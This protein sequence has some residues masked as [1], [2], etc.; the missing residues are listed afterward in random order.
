MD[1]RGADSHGAEQDGKGSS[2]DLHD[3]EQVMECGLECQQ[4]QEG[5]DYS[6]LPASF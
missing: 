2:G 1:S 3:C 4:S 5:T 6:L